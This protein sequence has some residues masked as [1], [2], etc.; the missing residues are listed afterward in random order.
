MEGPELRRLAETYASFMNYAFDPELRRFRNFMGYD[1]RWLEAQGSEDSQ[2]RALWALGTCAGRSKHR[3]LQV[4]AAQMF[5]RALPN[6]LDAKSPRTWA[7]TLLG[8]YEYFRRL[9]GDRVAALARIASPS[10]D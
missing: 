9:S 3:H 8:I 6:L 4:W 10:S 2:G 5:E 7:Y 1:R